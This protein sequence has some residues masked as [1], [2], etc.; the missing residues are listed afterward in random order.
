MLV[1]KTH[2]I[3]YSCK[4]FHCTYVFYLTI[5]LLM[6][7]ESVS[8]VFCCYNA[9]LKISAC[10][11]P[12]VHVDLHDRLLILI[13]IYRFYKLWYLSFIQQIFNECLLC[14]RHC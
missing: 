1:Y 8:C 9:A 13:D 3:L 2:S 7:S 14:A 6:A 10:V 4:L 11:Y 5:L 12:H